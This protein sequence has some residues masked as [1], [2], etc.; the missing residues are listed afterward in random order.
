MSDDDL[1]YVITSLRLSALIA[2]ADVTVALTAIEEIGRQLGVETIE[3]MSVSDWF[4]KHRVLALEHEL[5]AIE[6]KSSALAAKLQE[7]LDELKRK[8]G[9][10]DPE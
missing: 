7:H 5:V 9:I 2:R 1:D 6:N 3:D 10:I 4:A 8:G